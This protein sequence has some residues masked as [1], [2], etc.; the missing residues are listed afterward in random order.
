MA[1]PELIAWI[2]GDPVDALIDWPSLWADLL[3]VDMTLSARKLPAADAEQLFAR[4]ALWEAAVV[5]YGRTATTGRRR[6]RL[7]DLITA[8]GPDAEACHRE[9]M[10]WRNQHVAHRV[11]E[12]RESV[13]VGLIVDPEGHRLTRLHIRISTV[14]G[15]EDEGGDLVGRF[16][17]HVSMLR[18]AI[19]ETHFPALEAM[20]YPF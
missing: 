13:N 18:N 5:A 2:E 17:A 7:N 1:D 10:A 15:P 20:G 12:R 4:R 11:D 3:H 14:L 9:V 6:Q 8:Q 16:E 19:W